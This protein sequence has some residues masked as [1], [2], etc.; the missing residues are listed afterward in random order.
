MHH[1]ALF[2]EEGMLLCSLRVRRLSVSA[3]SVLLWRL[4]VLSFF[5]QFEI[6]VELQSEYCRYDV[7]C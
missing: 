5:V 3:F 1:M 6:R 4:L 7:D 2:A